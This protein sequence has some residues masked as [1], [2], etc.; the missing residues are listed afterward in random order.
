MQTTGAK[1]TLARIPGNGDPNNGDAMMK[2]I[3]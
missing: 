1:F 2:Y 3:S